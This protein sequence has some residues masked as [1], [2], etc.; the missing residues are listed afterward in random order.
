MENL[1]PIEQNFKDIRKVRQINNNKIVYE[2]LLY[3]DLKRLYENINKKEYERTIKDLELTEKEFLSKCKDDI[4][5]AKLASRN[6]SKNSSRQGSKDEIEQIK[7]CNIISSKCGVYLHQ[8]T[9]TELRPT[10]DGSI[11]SNNEMK[12]K[13]IQK[14]SC[15]KSFDAKISGRINGYISAKVAYGSGGHQDNVFTEI[16]TIAEWWKKYKYKSEELLILLID[17]DLTRKIKMLKEKYKNVTNL[18]IFN[19][20]EFQ[21]YIINTY[22]I[23]ESI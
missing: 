19:H 1:K 21:Y 7:T 15:L 8:L 11:I 17:T 9:T 13:N 10:K 5:F 18:K 3:N 20:I 12:L 4:F 16:D 14:E 6:F 23:N 22:H 2:S